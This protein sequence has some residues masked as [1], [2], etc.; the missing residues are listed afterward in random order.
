M[1]VGRGMRSGVSVLFPMFVLLASG[2]AQADGGRV[3]GIDA[4]VA[5]VGGAPLTTAQLR[6]HAVS[7]LRQVERTYPAGPERDVATRGALAA[8]LEDAIDDR[9]FE[10]E[11]R[12]RKLD[13]AADDVR[14]TLDRMM[15]EQ[16]V[17]PAD[18]DAT[19]D[20]WGYTRAELED[21]I[22]RAIVAQR[23]L[24]LD[25]SRDHDE[26]FP[27]TSSEVDA[28]RRE[29]LARRKREVGVER[30]VAVAK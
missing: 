4:I 2:A 16:H 28:Y 21:W 11:A 24:Y 14:Q 30:R 5:V 13:V 17:A 20:Q 6:R 8:D 7:R 15:A 23:V 1:G 27:T 10:D 25:W 22:R 19:I 12:R 18:V 9:L 26:P 29:W 3:I